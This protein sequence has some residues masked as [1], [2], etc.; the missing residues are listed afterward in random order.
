M[1]LRGTG[2]VGCD[3]VLPGDWCLLLH[4]GCHP[5][6]LDLQD[7]LCKWGRGFQGLSA[8]WPVSVPHHLSKVCFLCPSPAPARL[9][10]SPGQ[11]CALFICFPSMRLGARNLAA[12]RGCLLTWAV[13]QERTFAHQTPAGPAGH[14]CSLP[15]ETSCRVAARLSEAGAGAAPPCGAAGGPRGSSEMRSPPAR[16]LPP[17]PRMN[18]LFNKMLLFSNVFSRELVWVWFFVVVVL[19][20]SRSFPPHSAWQRA[21]LQQNSRWGPGSGFVGRPT[22]AL[23]ASWARPLCRL[24]AYS[25]EHHHPPLP[26]H[27]SHPEHGRDSPRGPGPRK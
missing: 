14:Q 22:P 11:V 26:C 25:Y 23:P 3:L 19:F 21:R 24:Y 17:A 16:L 8:L 10:H 20:L 5:K 9:P 15:G 13:E 18:S 6:T 2:E 12:I 4:P 7:P 1:A 27:R